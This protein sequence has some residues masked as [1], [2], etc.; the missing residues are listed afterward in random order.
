[1]TRRIKLERLGV[2]N[3]N[4]AYLGAYR[5]QVQVAEIEDMPEEIFIHERKV[6]P[7]T[8]EITDTFCAVASPVDIYEMP[9]NAPNSES[10]YFRKSSMDGYVR[11]TAEA[12]DIWNS[13]QR[14]TC[15]LIE[16]LNRYDTLTVIATTWC[17]EAPP[18][19]SDSS[20]SS[21]SP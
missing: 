20:A 10:A 19:S 14:E 2:E 17:P 8:A 16:A 21:E 13:I 5:L 11:S 12:E 4:V 6:D 3:A 1:M 9:I 7:D 18:D 15:I